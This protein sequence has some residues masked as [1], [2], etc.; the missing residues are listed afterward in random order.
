[1]LYQNHSTIK[2]N[3][4]KDKG[5]IKHSNDLQQFAKPLTYTGNTID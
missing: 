2:F 1:M 4:L 3:F 5:T